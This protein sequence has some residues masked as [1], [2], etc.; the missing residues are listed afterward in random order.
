[1]TPDTPPT[2]RF[3]PTLAALCRVAGNVAASLLAAWIWS[4]VAR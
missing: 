3:R 2:R 1:M 4:L